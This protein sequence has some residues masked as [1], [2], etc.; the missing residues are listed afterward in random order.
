MCPIEV[1]TKLGMMPDTQPGDQ[2]RPGDSLP[3]ESTT[4]D[5]SGAATPLTD[6]ANYPLYVVTAAAGNEVSGCLAGFVT[7]SSLH[8]VRF[9]VCISTVN[10]TFGV[11][12]RADALGLHALGR[13][14]LD[15]A[16][17]FGETTGDGTDKFSTTKWTRR[18]TGAPILTECAAWVEGPILTHMSAGDHE[19]FLIGIANGGRGTHGGRF[20]LS[21]AAGFEPGHPG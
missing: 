19:A 1:A 9:L 7:Q 2:I 11:A 3:V 6:G 10:H 8:P 20:M 14:Q 15:L 16:A 4:R 17:L 13:D 18:T 5:D 12:M 21:D